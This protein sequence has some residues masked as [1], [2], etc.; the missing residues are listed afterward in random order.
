MSS[1]LDYQ[2][3]QNSEAAQIS[4]EAALASCKSTREKIYAYTLD[5]NVEDNLHE[6]IEGWIGFLIII[7]LFALVVERIPS[8]FEPNAALF[9]VF[10]VF[11]VIVFTIEYLLRLYLAPEDH[12]FK[13]KK[14]PHASYFLSPFALIDFC[15]V[16][17]FYFQAF[18]PIDLRVLRFLRLLRMLKLFRVLIPAYKEFQELNANRT[19][20]QKMHALVFPSPYGGALSG[21][22]ENVIVWWV[23]ISVIAVI[24]ESVESIHYIF[25][26]QFIIVDSIAVGLFS[27]EYFLKLYSCVE[28]PQYKDWMTGRIKHSLKFSSIVDFLA[29]VPF[30]LEL[31]LHHQFDLRFLRIFRLM[32]LLKLSKQNNSTEV[33]KRVFTRET[34]I[35]AASLFVMMLMVVLAAS[36]VYLI[37][38][39]AQPD[40][41]ENIPSSI[42]WAV[43]T[44]SS[45]GYGDLTPV[46]TV[47]R[48]MTIFMAMIGVG[49]FAI[50]SAL[51]AASFSDELLKDKINL[52]AKFYQRLKSGLPVNE[53][54]HYVISEAAKINLSGEQIKGIIDEVCYNFKV[55]EDLI[56]QPL[57]E[58]ASNPDHALEHF[59][60]TLSRIRQLGIMLQYGPKEIN[61]QLTHL[62]SPGEAQ[63]WREIQGSNSFLKSAN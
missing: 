17:P 44:L 2:D 48:L 56:K 59:V 57:A 20:R 41:Y 12:E 29:I 6:K 9:H 7:N 21:M 33:L 8:I 18:I 27:I 42:Y 31:F 55:E 53:K 5:P 43:I 30:F 50:P 34:P 19:F 1:T 39:D 45:V 47:G 15:A 36:L 3:K 23:V 14:I 16:A 62:L 11:S 38:H 51:L 63:L 40:K 32:R 26:A 4:L 22:F 46:T 49:I 58:I 24:F 28:D 52:S 60:K 25:N 61:E 54:D 13:N 37:E 10:D 35:L